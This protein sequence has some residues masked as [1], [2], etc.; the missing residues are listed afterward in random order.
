MRAS[1][2]PLVA[3]LVLGCGVSEPRPDPDAAPSPPVASVDALDLSPI[4]RESFDRLLAAR[5]FTDDAI[6]D[7]GITP[8]E[9]RALRYLLRE[10][11]AAAAFALLERDATLPGRLFALCGLHTTDRARFDARVG[12]YRDSSET[13]E[14]QTG[15]SLILDQRVGELVERPAERAVRLAPN[16]TNREHLARREGSVG[17]DIVGGGFPNLFA[18][19]GGWHSADPEPFDP[20]AD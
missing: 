18:Q 19:G 10:E 16:E 6:Y 7:G 17:Y 2:L 13:I 20:D 4:G 5:R 1:A 3:A 9:V 14:F 8:N 11:R 15:C 12:H